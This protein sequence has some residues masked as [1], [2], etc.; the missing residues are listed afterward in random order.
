MIWIR[1]L[2]GVNKMYKF[3]VI[4]SLKWYF[5]SKNL[6][7]SNA[8][9]LR[10]PLSVEN[11]KDLRLYYSQYFASLVSAV[12][13]LS[14]NKNYPFYKEFVSS[15]HQSF[16]FEKFTDGEKNYSYIRELRNSIVHR[17]YDISSASHF[18]NYFPLLIAPLVTKNP[19][20]LKQYPAI[21]FYLI[22]VIEICEKLIGNII[23]THIESFANKLLVLTDIELLEQSKQFV[24]DSVV[25]PDWV[26]QQALTFFE[27]EDFS[28]IKVDTTDELIV[29]LRKNALPLDLISQ[30]KSAQL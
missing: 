25:M 10:A 27:N 17:G 12:E 13:F 3:E 5:E 16:I 30:L 20:G 14:D 8:L 18:I 22:E 23:A 11:Q 15:L 28:K 29:F 9:L 26:K 19:T 4:A 1:C 7:L 6:S 21:G 2:C 24:I